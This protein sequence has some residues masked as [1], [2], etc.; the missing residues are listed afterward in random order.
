MNRQHRGDTSEI[1]VAGK[2]M[3][4]G[5]TVLRPLSDN[6]RYDLAID[7]NG[8]FVRVQVKTAEQRDNGAIV[9][10]CYTS[11]VNSNTQ[12]SKHYTRDEID[13]F[14]IYDEARKRYFWV[15]VDEAPKSE[16]TLRYESPSNEMSKRVNWCEN[17]V[18]G[19]KLEGR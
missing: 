8:E 15:D 17:Y 2:L 18:L 19:E 14:V 11:Q 10:R 16:M 3:E 6:E 9:F 1:L 13:A 7:M 5:F 4:L 12:N